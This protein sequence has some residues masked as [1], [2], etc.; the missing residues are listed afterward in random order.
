MN[1]SL[2]HCTDAQLQALIEQNNENAVATLLDRYKSNF[3]TTAYLLVR[4]QYIAEDI[5]Q[6]VCI[7]VIQW[8]RQGKYVDDGKFVAWAA[9][10]TRNLSVDYLR[11]VKR[12]PKVVMSDGL[13]IFSVLDF[14]EKNVQDNWIRKEEESQVHELLAMIPYEQRE[15]IVL[16]LYGELSFKE[17]AQLIGVN[18]N[19][20]LGRM[21]Y[22]IRS[23]RKMRAK[24][25]MLQ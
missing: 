2:Q 13:D 19:T 7:K 1:N 14:G 15:V 3:Y 16:R 8:I 17:I 10:V 25:G 20:A 9:R 6:E 23:L 4:D 12:T 11:K 5:F 21:R 18:L 22:G 24:S